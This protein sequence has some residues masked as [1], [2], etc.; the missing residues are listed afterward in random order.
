MYATRV[1]EMLDQYVVAAR[2]KMRL[3][4][5]NP[6]P[7]SDVEDQAL[8]FGLQGAP[9]N[10]QGETVYFG[11]AGTNS[12]DDQQVIPFFSPDREQF[13]EYDLTRLKSHTLGVS[14]PDQGSGCCR[15]CRSKATRWRAIP[16]GAAERADGG[17]RPV[18]PAR[19]CRRLADRRGRRAPMC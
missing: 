3:E 10:E 5:Y 15:P 8:G 7:F 18:A 1:R 16:A 13:L 14:E 2:G 17:A 12:T 6:L 9:L 19:R 4:V 11:L